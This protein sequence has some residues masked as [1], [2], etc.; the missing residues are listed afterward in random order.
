MVAAKR[1]LGVQVLYKPAKVPTRGI[2]RYSSVHV[3]VVRRGASIICDVAGLLY[4]MDG[5]RTVG[6][7]SAVTCAAGPSMRAGA[8]SLQRDLMQCRSY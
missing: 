3:R 6:S 4:G 5:T 2:K 1:R 7:L 8:G